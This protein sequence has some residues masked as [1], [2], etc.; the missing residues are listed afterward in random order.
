MGKKEDA[1]PNTGKFDMEQKHQRP[2][3][4]VTTAPLRA[5]EDFCSFSLISPGTLFFFIG[6]NDATCTRDVYYKVWNER[7]SGQFNA[8]CITNCNMEPLNL[9][10]N[11]VVYPIV[12]AML[13][14]DPAA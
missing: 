5:K 1:F 14:T 12:R 9:D 2:S 11:T 7:I 6:R 13:L 3:T 10:E 8:I 4:E